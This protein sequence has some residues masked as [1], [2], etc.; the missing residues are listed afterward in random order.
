MSQRYTI[1]MHVYPHAGG[2]CSDPGNNRRTAC[3]GAIFYFFIF[4]F[5]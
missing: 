3:G 4:L 5:F 1:P 2:E